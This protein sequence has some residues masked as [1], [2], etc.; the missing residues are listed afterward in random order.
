MQNKLV[1]PFAALLFV[2][3]LL[4]CSFLRT[5]PQYKWHL[6]L[7]VDPS[8][9]GRKALTFDTVA[10]LKNRLDRV[11]VTLS[12]VQIVGDPENGRVRVDLP[13]VKD[14]Q[15][16]KNFI[17]SRGLLE[18]VHVVSDPSPAPYQT[19]ATEEEAKATIKSEEKRRV[20]LYP[21]SD[22]RNG[23]NVRWLVIELPPIIDGRDIRS[24]RAIPSPVGDNYEVS[25]TLTAAGAEKFGSW[26]AANI[27][28]Y[29]GVV[30][31][32]EIRSVSFIKGQILDSGIIHGSFTRQSAEDLAMVLSSG[33]LPAVVKVLEEGQN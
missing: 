29:L 12:K 28:Q 7:E 24:A 27:N 32:D 19:Y 1:A 13:A 20:L 22:A 9:S 4:A 17:V 23:N 30:L 21:N 11:G 6:I 14:P 5:N 15:R 33:P 2:T 18:L 31:N 16:M 26:T 25:F 8:V 3:P 10:L